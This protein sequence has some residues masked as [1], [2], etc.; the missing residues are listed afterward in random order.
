MAFYYNVPT[1]YRALN[2]PVTNEPLGSDYAEMVKRAGTLN[3]IFAG[4]GHNFTKPIDPYVIPGD[5]KSGLLPRIDPGPLGNNGTCN[6]RDFRS[7]HQRCRNTG[8]SIGSF[9]N[10]S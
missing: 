2:C 3:G 9:A 5:P 7:A 8:R 1:K 4:R 6:G 10:T